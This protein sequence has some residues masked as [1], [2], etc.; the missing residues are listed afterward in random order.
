MYSWETA[1]TTRDTNRIVRPLEWG[2]DW[3]QDFSPL[4]LAANPHLSDYDRMTAVNRDIVARADEFY[5]YETPTDFRLERRHPQLY[6]T[7]VRPETLQQDAELR[8]QAETGEI[9]AADFLRFTSPIRTRYPE[10][11]QVNARWY[12]AHPDSQKGK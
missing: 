4:A 2:F 10:N 8:R 12:P 1:L 7:N 3:L 9:E 5:S 11:D 6:P